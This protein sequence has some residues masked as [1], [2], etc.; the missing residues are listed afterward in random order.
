LDTGI[1]EEKVKQ[2]YLKAGFKIVKVIEKYDIALYE[3]EV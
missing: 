3:F 2:I 1:N